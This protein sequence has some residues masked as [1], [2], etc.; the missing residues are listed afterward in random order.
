MNTHIRRRSWMARTSRAMTVGGRAR[1]NKQAMTVGVWGE[2][3]NEK[4]PPHCWDGPSIVG[5]RPAG[6]PQPVARPC[7]F[8]QTALSGANPSIEAPGHAMR[9][10]L[11]TMV[12]HWTTSFQL[13]NRD[14]EDRG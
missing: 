8:R 13:L 12:R 2:G 9:P 11:E 3:Q 4:G 5:P 7:A 14:S 6:L 1:R 10:Q